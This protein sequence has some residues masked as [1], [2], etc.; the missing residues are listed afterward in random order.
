MLRFP[1]VTLVRFFANH[2]FL[3]LQGQHQWRTVV[4]GSRRYR[5]A[6]IRPFAE[7]IRTQHAVTS[8]H[9]EGKQMR[10]RLSDGTDAH[11]DAVVLAC[12]ADEALRM[13]VSPTTVQEALLRPWNYQRNVATLHTD[14]S[15]MPKAKRAW[16]SWNYR[17][18]DQGPSTVYWMNSLQQ[19][20]KRMNYFVSIND[21]EEL[22]PSR[23]LKRIEYDHPLYTLE[24]IATQS[25]LPT[26]NESGGIY[27][28]GSY[29]RYGFHEDALTSGLQAA[30]ALK[31]RL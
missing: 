23:V 25:R 22:D 20:S 19:V 26:L 2:R 4:G 29:F 28:C 27:F 13:L 16:A 5:D 6:L 17:I 11:F 7:C 18:T 21:P 15:V 31:R 8:V 12:H 1:V 30:A 14:E 10:V 3:S 24:S 9:Q